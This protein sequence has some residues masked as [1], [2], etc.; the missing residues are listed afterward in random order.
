MSLK[1][2]AEALAAVLAEARRTE[3]ETVPLAEASGRTLAERL[4]AK[5][6]QPPFDVS[7][8]DGY[9]VCAADTAAPPARLSLAGE[10]AAGRR[11][12]GRISAGE[13]ARIFT[14][15][16][17]PD[18][19]DAILIQE[20]AK[21]HGADITALEAV[22]AGRHIRRA[23]YDFTKG[24]ELLAAGRRLNARDLGLAAA[25]DHAAVSVFRKPRIAIL[26]T[27]DELVMPG[28]AAGPD[29][30]TASN[31]FA[32]AAMAA[33]AGGEP[34][35]LGIAR[36]TLASLDEAINR[37]LS[38]KADALVTLGGAS[39][40]DHDLVREALTARGMTLGFWKIAMR[41]GKPLMFGR[42]GGMLALG[43]PGNPVSSIV[44]AE[45]FLKPLIR[46]LSGDPEAGADRSE[47]AVLGRDLPAND[48]RQDYLRASLSRGTA[49]A[50]VAT[51]FARQDSSLLADIAKAEAL[52]IRAPFAAAA[53]AGERVSVI[54]L[55]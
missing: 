38:W 41:P 31:T 21:A 19:A 35:D 54:R 5:R 8:M 49:G 40:G 3:T 55:G 27:G 39:A 29:Q 26:A 11:F 9:A 34:R 14:G 7:A 4:A 6:T 32:V 24:Q 2:V 48:Q 17:V 43:L 46:A 25:M 52:V 45:L 37:A 20:N 33:S 15:A 28:E 51:P 30:I 50:L 53:K 10:S 44:C 36:D 42:L 1:P 13:C 23:G 12:S 22:A 47:E 18:G 16:P